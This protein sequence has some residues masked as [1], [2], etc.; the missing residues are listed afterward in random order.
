MGNL[1]DLCAANTSQIFPICE[2][3]DECTEQWIRR[4]VPLEEQVQGTIEFVSSLN[5]TNVTRDIPLLDELLSLARDIESLLSNS[6][7]DMLATDVENF[8]ARLCQLINQTDDLLV[9]GA[10]V[11]AELDRIGAGREEIQRRLPVLMNS[12]AQLRTDFENISMIFETQEFASVNSTFYIELARRALERSNAA[13]LLVRENVTSIL[14]ETVLL[15]E[16]FNATLDENDVI[17]TSER[18]QEAVTNINS[19]VG[20]MQAFIMIASQRL[21]GMGNGICLE[22]MNESCEVCPSGI[23]CDGLIAKADLASNISTSTL[24]MAED[25]L[26]QIMSEVQVLEELLDRARRVQRGAD[27]VTNFVYEIRNAS[28]ELIENIQ[29][30]TNELER[31]LNATRV[32]PDDIGCLENMT[33]SLQLD[34]LPN[35]VYYK[36]TLHTISC[37]LQSYSILG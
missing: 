4:I 12:L 18:L 21:C 17:G 22:C 14:N 2:P 30:L 25:L 37:H 11:Q 31:E 15:L 35:E 20:E 5:L 29:L 26:Q 16:M 19:T 9:R 8:N 10:A 32:V 13:D 34:L 6:T 36:T 33:L 24:A 27:E 23:R 1:C 28:L 7:F 3:C